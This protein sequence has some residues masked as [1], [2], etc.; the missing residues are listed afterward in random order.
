MTQ[1]VYPTPTPTWPGL[2]HLTE[3]P[4]DPLLDLDRNVGQRQSTFVFQL[5]NGITGL[6]KGFVTPL[7]GTGTALTHDTT[8]TTKRQLSIALGVADTAL[9]Q[10]ETDRILVYMLTGGLTY[11]LGRYAFT[12][13]QDAVS[14]GGSRS[15]DVLLDEMTN[16]DLQLEAGF[17]TVAQASAVFAVETAVALLL[18][19]L[20]FITGVDIAS[21]PFP[22]VGAWS[23]GTTRGQ[24]LAA[25]A[26]QGDYQTPWFGNDGHFKMIRT[27]N[28]EEAEPTIDMDRGARVIRDSIT[29]TSTLLVA[30]NR[31]IVISNGG[32]AQA[33]PIVGR[34]DVPPSA[35]NSIQSIGFVRPSVSNAQ[36]ATQDQ[37]NAAARQLGLN[38]TITRTVQLATPPDP[39]HD[40]YDVVRWQGQNWLEIAWSMQLIEG[41]QMTHTLR[42]SFV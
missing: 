35:P 33:A 30:P 28:P 1:P 37:A 21:S 26:Q 8:R 6:H 4:V 11:R 10:E 2:T 12:S 14:T 32:E 29:A 13:E 27:V 16:V 38:N 34:Y 9:V 36:L 17:P 22:I 40:S 18:D 31:F 23:P 3:V 39:R 20:P 5:I 25:M 7:R 42:R 24:V 19:G 15:S 41:G